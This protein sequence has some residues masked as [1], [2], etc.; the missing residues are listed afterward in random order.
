MALAYLFDPCK[1]WQNRA[2][3]NNVSG[4]LEVFLMNTD[5]HATVYTDFERSAVQRSH[6][7]I[8]NDGRAVMVVDAGKVYRIEMHDPQ[9]NLIFTQQPVY[10]VG[11]GSGNAAVEVISTDGTIAVDK[12]TSGG[13]KIFDLSIAE[14]S[15][16]SLDWIRCEGSEPLG[17]N[18]YRP[19]YASGTMSLGEQ[20]ILLGADRYYHVTAHVRATKTEI[21]PFYDNFTVN[22]KTR[23]G[24][25][26]TVRSSTDHLLDFSL[27]LTQEFEVSTDVF[28][29]ENCELMFE[30]VS[31]SNHVTY[32]LVD[33]ELHRVYSGL[34]QG[35]GGDD[36]IQSDWTEE[37]SAEPSYI[38]HKPEVKTV[39][40][41]DNIDITEGETTFTI[42]ADLSTVQ[43]QIDTLSG[44]ISTLQSAL[45]TLSTAVNGLQTTVGTLQSQ[46]TYWAGQ[47]NELSSKVSTNTTNLSSLDSRYGAHG[48][49]YDSGSHRISHVL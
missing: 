48:N 26:D 22:I 11:R 4:Y 16:S 41:G 12:T 40:E 43:S 21:D 6:I 14:D 33:V 15:A 24:S 17:Q 5:T 29:S 13:T 46:M 42:S 36:R 31:V 3:V 39:V 28:T 37:N 25:I 38:L 19:I 8:D 10:P 7:G 45:N 30:I 34:P 44:Q 1:Q 23:S 2:G 32:S 9:G 49:N 35:G 27:G 20:G 47:V 18:F